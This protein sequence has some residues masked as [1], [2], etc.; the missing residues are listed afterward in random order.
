MTSPHFLSNKRI[1]VS[2]AGVAGLAFAI[3]LL[4]QWPS[5]HHPPP[6]LAIYERDT[7]Q[8]ATGREGYSLG[9]RSDPPGGLQALQKLGLLDRIVEA[10]VV[11][12]DESSGASMCIWD[13]D[14]GELLRIRA[15][16]PPGL[17]VAGT[18]I[19]RNVAA[20]RPR[21]RRG[22]GR[23]SGQLGRRLYRGDRVAGDGRL[24]LRL[25]D[26]RSD[27]CDL[28][29][30]ADGGSSKIRAQLRPKDGLEFRGVLRSDG[31]VALRRAAAGAGPPRLRHGAQRHGHGH[32]RVAGGRAF[33]AVGPQLVRGHAEG[34]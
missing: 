12:M 16:A 1:C 28:V 8:G 33:R 31:H 5:G 23:V 6:T 2:G 4:K 3:A 7:E 10:S 22:G 30:A 14:L 24:E 25:G 11:V 18:R 34:E 13:R 32:V 9:L 27:V 20:G 15:R 26:G 29:V 19:A 17:P 21:A